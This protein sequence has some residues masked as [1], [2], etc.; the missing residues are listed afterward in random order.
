M[1]A[2]A[3]KIKVLVVEDSVVVRELLVRILESDPA[4]Q[5]VG[6]ASDGGVWTFS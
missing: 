6:V 1:S 5:V 4:I 2:R 3:G